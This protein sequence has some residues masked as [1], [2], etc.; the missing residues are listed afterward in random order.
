M[1]HVNLMIPLRVIAKNWYKTQKIVIKDIVV[2]A[3]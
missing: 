1:A 2:S 3:I